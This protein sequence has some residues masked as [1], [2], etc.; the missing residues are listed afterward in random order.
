MLEDYCYFMFCIGNLIYCNMCVTNFFNIK[1]FLKFPV[2]FFIAIENIAENTERYG[3][4]E[5]KYICK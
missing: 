5:L 3:Q 2:V 4:G 1:I